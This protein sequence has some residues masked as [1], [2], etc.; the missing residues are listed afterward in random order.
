[1][2]G[3]QQTGGPN[4]SLVPGP[5]T[6]S[7]R[8]V[9]AGWEPGSRSHWFPDLPVTSLPFQHLDYGSSQGLKL[10]MKKKNQIQKLSSEPYFT[11]KST[12]K[13]QLEKISNF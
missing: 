7:L 9:E 11:N 6:T 2:D 1:M 4:P 10:P 12:H 5:F 3:R 8:E 13:G